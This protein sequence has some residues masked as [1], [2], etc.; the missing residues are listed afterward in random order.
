MS[1]DITFCEEIELRGYTLKVSG[2]RYPSEK[3]NA[4]KPEVWPEIEIEEIL[5]NGHKESDLVIWE[6]SAEIKAALIQKMQSEGE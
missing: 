6:L 4:L 5:N 3:G 2:I 1:R